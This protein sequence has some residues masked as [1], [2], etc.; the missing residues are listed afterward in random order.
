[1]KIGRWLIGL[2]AFAAGL[3]ATWYFAS[4][5]WT[6]RG[7]KQA[8]EAGDTQALSA[9]I[10]Y[11]AVREDV[12]R[13]VRERYA[14]GGSLESRLLRGVVAEGIVEAVVRPEGLKAA[15][16]A[17]S[18]VRSP[19]AMRAEDVAMRRDGLDEFRLANRSGEG[20]ELVFHRHG[21][22]WKLA[23]VQLPK[24]LPLLGR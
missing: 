10:D 5:W 21:L 11:P 2:A 19:L 4:P 17:G 7:M 9:Y 14:G 18:M 24:K 3:G 23:G 6:L 13:Q 8:A 1:M 16:V 20:A 15:L 22:G 12:R